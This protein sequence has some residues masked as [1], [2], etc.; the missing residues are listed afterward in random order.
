PVL[1]LR[2]AVPG[3]AARHA[4]PGPSGRAGG[5]A[6]L[7]DQRLTPDPAVGPLPIPAV[8]LAGYTPRTGRRPRATSPGE[9]SRSPPPA[10]GP[11]PSFP[12]RAANPL[13]D[14][15]AGCLGSVPYWT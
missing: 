15:P 6:V 13:P 7:R 12:P 9:A 8:P 2:P 4:P 10:A 3:V 11:C 1:E 5:A 14:R